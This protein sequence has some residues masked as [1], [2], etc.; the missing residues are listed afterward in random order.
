MSDKSNIAICGYPRSGSTMF[1][2]MLRSTVLGYNFTD[3]ERSAVFAL[4][5]N[6]WPLITKFP[7]DCFYWRDIL[8]IDQD[9]RFI[10]TIRD[11]RSVIC[12]KHATTG[13][14]YKVSWN[15]TI[16]GR[17]WSKLDKHHRRA[18]AGKGRYR[19]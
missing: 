5:E 16:F 15:K 17:S 2:N 8:E 12:S 3:E 11:P 9:V 1:Y 7:S 10:A 4:N 6:P 19:S 13:D 18:Q 14:R